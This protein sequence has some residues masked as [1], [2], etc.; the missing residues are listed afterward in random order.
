MPQV[1]CVLRCICIQCWP[2]WS[3]FALNESLSLCPECLNKA[4][5]VVWVESTIRQSGTET[6]IIIYDCVSVV[7]IALGGGL[8]A[9]DGAALTEESRASR[10]PPTRLARP[11]VVASVLCES[12]RSLSA[13]PTCTSRWRHVRTWS[14]PGP[15]RLPSRRQ[16]RRRRRPGAWP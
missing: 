11:R 12:T 3:D 16:R 2:T 13:M 14:G 4:L 15:P 8:G 1:G 9:W 6:Q 10:S 7:A 5:C